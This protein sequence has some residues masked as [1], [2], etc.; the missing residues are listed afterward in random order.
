MADFKQKIESALSPVAEK[1]AEE[2]GLKL[3]RINI[4]GTDKTPVI[5]V[6]LDGERQV[7]LEDCE[8]I[9]RKLDEFLN[10]NASLSQNFRL[11]VLSPGVEEPLVQDFQYIRSLGKLVEVHYSDSGEEHTIHG[12]LREYR[13]TEIALEPA[14]KKG[15]KTVVRDEEVPLPLKRD[16]QLYDAPVELVRID[17]KKVKKA[18]VQVLFN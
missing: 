13:Q 5:E 7:S 12:I 10:A 2:R 18:I 17:R 14:H 4:R 9:S 1:A 16:E 8:D 3:L 11:D 15:K 6:I